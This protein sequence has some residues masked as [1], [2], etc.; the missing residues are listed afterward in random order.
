MGLSDVK[1]AVGNEHLSPEKMLALAAFAKRLGVDPQSERILVAYEAVNEALGNVKGLTTGEA[2]FTLTLIVAL[3]TDHVE[4][5][6]EKVKPH[7]KT[8]KVIQSPG[9]A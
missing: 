6:V 1:E 3:A 7:F 8:P 4:Q 2:L 5:E 9:N